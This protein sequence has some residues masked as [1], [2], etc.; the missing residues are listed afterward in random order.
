[1]YKATRFTT[2]GLS[3]TEFFYV[4][5]APCSTTPTQNKINWGPW[6]VALN[7]LQWAW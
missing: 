2:L 1:M 4:N 5:S 3:T 7:A 6:R